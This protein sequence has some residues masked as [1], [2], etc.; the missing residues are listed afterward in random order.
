MAQDDTSGLLHT[1]KGSPQKEGVDD[2]AQGRQPSKCA[3][4]LERA[5]QDVRNYLREYMCCKDTQ[6][7]VEEAT[8]AIIE[9]VS[10][11]DIV[12]FK[13]EG[14]GFCVRAKQLLVEQGYTEHASLTYKETLGTSPA[15]RAALKS[16]T[17]VPAV[18]FPAIFLRGRFLGGGDELH[19]AVETGSISS[20]LAEPTATL[21]PAGSVEWSSLLKDT[22]RPQL[23]T[24]PRQGRW[25]YFHMYT[26]ANLIRAISFLH[27]IFFSILIFLTQEG[28]PSSLLAA[29]VILWY[30]LIDTSLYVVFGPSPWSPLGVLTTVV[31]W[32]RRANSTSTIPY[33][34]VFC[35]YIYVFAS[36]LLNPTSKLTTGVFVSALVNSAALAILRF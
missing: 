32:S 19:K 26:Y 12:M 23:F 25:F 4:V 30:L 33:K 2:Q 17:N 28:S 27:V 21:T 7:D 35:Y 31:C 5:Q 15:L 36:A 16:L 11:F 18:T 10:N 8:N 29:K 24:V 3:R 20:L 22:R 14:C 9:Q 1:A 13:K 6:G 34:V